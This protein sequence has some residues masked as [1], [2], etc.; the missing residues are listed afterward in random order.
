MNLDKEILKHL[1]S[2]MHRHNPY[3]HLYKQR[4]LELK[5]KPEYNL[6]IK[7]DTKVDRRIYN[8][9]TASEVAILL[10][11]NEIC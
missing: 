1:Q 8:L 7:S 2:L 6:I 10:P 3:V 5:L 4:A 9:P 11:G